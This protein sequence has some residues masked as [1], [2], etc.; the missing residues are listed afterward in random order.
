MFLVFYITHPDEAAAKH[1]A[2]TLLERRLIA[3]ANVFPIQSA[4]WWEGDVQ[5]EGEWVSLLKT[6]SDLELALEAAVRALHPYEVPCIMRYEV[7]A[8]AEYEQ[9]IVES[10]GGECSDDTKT[11]S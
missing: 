7:R 8:N 3:C 5:R 1:I 10:T 11:L 2:D 9:W 6:R 4:Y